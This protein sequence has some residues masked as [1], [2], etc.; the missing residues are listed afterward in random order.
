[1]KSGLGVGI[2]AV[3]LNAGCLGRIC[4]ATGIGGATAG[5][6]VTTR[7]QPGGRGPLSSMKGLGAY[8]AASLLSTDILFLS[9]RSR[10]QLYKSVFNGKLFV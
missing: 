9:G 7:V 6:Y 1:M 2:G 4:C 8:L 10:E 5:T 3:G